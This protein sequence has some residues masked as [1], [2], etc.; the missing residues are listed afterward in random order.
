MLN[1]SIW[2]SS[3]IN[4]DLRYH[5]RCLKCSFDRFT[6]FVVCIREISLGVCFDNCLGSQSSGESRGDKRGF[7]FCENKVR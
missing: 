7:N 3:S 1:R 4:N 5:F 6:G 2:R